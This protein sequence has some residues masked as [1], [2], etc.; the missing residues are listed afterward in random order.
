[1]NRNK[2][3]EDFR[4]DILTGL[5][6]PTTRVELSVSQLDNAINQALKQFWKFH[7]DGTF[8]NYYLYQATDADVAKGYIPCPLWIDA[9]LEV[10]PQG[11][12]MSD[13]SFM[14]VEYQMA[15]EQWLM[16]QN[17]MNISLSDYVC[18]QEQI[19]NMRQIISSPHTFTHVRYQRRIIPRFPFQTGD[20]LAFRVYEN[21]D[22]ERT[23]PGQVDCPGV[24][25]DETLKN[26]G[27]AYAMQTWGMSLMKYGNITLPG[28]VV[29]DGQK[30]YDEGNNQANEILQ[31]LMYRFPIDFQVG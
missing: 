3:R 12:S 9:V 17:F 27:Q 2:T 29:L 1:M 22:P 19:Y 21:V 23:D 8:E 16:P 30:I 4:Q 6:Y 28:G 13:L 14:T 26:L 15:R 24:F 25:D 11:F 20:V 10:I 31:E 7:P 5:G 18:L